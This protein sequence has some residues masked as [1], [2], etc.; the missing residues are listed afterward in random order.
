MLIISGNRSLAFL[1]DHE[2]KP[3]MVFAWVGFVGECCL[4]AKPGAARKLWQTWSKNGSSR[5]RRTILT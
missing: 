3:D 2:E 5:N 1:D 4:V